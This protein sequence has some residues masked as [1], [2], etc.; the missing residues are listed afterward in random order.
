MVTYISIMG[1][2][3]R[4]FLL[5]VLSRSLLTCCRSVKMISIQQAWGAL[6]FIPTHQELTVEVNS[7][8][9][10]LLILPFSLLVMSSG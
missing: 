10:L 1:C 6:S 9:Y 2:D 8:T 7:G 4:F 5:K 3:V